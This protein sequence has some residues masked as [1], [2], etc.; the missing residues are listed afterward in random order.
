MTT[1]G[2]IF[3]LLSWGLIIGLFV[4]TMSRALSDKETR[5]EE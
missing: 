1:G 3:M 4:Y 2:W 5:E